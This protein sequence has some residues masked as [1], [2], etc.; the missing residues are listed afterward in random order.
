MVLFFLVQRSLKFQVSANSIVMFCAVVI[1][2]SR[3]FWQTEKGFGVLYIQ[4]WVF[5]R[6]QYSLASDISLRFSCIVKAEIVY[7]FPDL[8]LT[9][10][11]VRWY[12]ILHLPHCYF[13]SSND[14]AGPSGRAV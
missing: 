10:H 4:C 5:W 14:H 13:R 1:A 9:C 2:L 6:L 12:A 8:A 7:L 3:I 11:L